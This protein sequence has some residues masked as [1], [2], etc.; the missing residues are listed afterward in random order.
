[1]GCPDRERGEWQGDAVLEMEEC[2]YAVEMSSHKLAKNFMLTQQIGQLAGQN[3]IAHGEYV[4]W[5]Y[6]LYTGDR[7]TLKYIYPAKKNILINIPSGQTGFRI[8]G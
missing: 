4:D 1:M 8:S 7:E 3:L 6:Y 5:T 2:F